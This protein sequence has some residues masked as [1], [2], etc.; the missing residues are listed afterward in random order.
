MV[1]RPPVGR[2]RVSS[3]RIRGGEAGIRDSVRDAQLVIERH[4][5]AVLGIGRPR[6]AA[7]RRG[8]R[9]AEKEEGEAGRRGA[10]SDD[11]QEQGGPAPRR[12]PHQVAAVTVLISMVCRPLTKRCVPVTFTLL[13][14]NGMSFEFCGSPGFE[15]TGKYIVPSLE[16]MPSGTPALAHA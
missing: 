1:A 13:S 16:S 10:A 9:A 14:A 2:P 6:Q 11:R 4:E 15:L 7:Q 12:S 3:S 5:P 8:R